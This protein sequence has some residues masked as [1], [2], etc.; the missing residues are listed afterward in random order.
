MVLHPT[1]NTGFGISHNLLAAWT[2]GKDLSNTAWNIYPAWGSA[3]A[4]IAASNAIITLTTF[5]AEA[6]T[7]VDKEFT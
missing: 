2:N 7:E 5:A 6:V 4:G 1:L 3:Y